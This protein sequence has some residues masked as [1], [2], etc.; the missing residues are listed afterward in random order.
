MARPKKP[1]KVTWLSEGTTEDLRGDALESPGDEG[2][3]EAE[4]AE[5]Y[6]L[7]GQVR[8]EGIAD[9]DPREKDHGDPSSQTSEE[10]GAEGS[11]AE[12]IDSPTEE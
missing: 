10:S 2:V 12:D 1:R 9:T 4:R 8:I 6:E 3:L 7:H 5:D 11:E